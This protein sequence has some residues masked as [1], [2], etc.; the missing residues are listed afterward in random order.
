ML[1]AGGRGGG[2]RYCI[3]RGGANFQIAWHRSSFELRSARVR[4]GGCGCTSSLLE[5]VLCE[6]FGANELVLLRDLWLLS[7]FALGLKAEAVVIILF[8]GL[9]SFILGFALLFVESAL[10]VLH[11]C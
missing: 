7:L 11:G 4:S 9:A 3:K 10:L 1:A 6:R 2:T 5:N 8:S